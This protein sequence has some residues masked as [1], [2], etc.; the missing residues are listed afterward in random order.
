MLATKEGFDALEAEVSRLEKEMLAAAERLEFELA[1]E[2]RDR[3]RYLREKAVVGMVVDRRPPPDEAGIVVPFIGRPART[4]T[5]PAIAAAYCGTP[6]VPVSCTPSADGRYTIRIRP[7]IQP[8]GRDPEAI[9]TAAGIAASEAAASGVNWTFAPMVDISRDPR[10]GRVTE[11]AG[12]DLVV[13]LG[14]PEHL[15]GDHPRAHNGET[16]AQ[17]RYNGA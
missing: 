13:A 6:A 15:R 11:G 4:C 8:E 17:L 10:W 5:V 7:S 3:I 2:K 12:E 16:E 14:L 1:A 9:E